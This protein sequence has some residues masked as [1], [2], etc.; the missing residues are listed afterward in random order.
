MAG[1]DL[2]PEQRNWADQVAK[3]LNIAMSTSPETA[4]PEP[5][6]DGYSDLT[7][8]RIGEDPF[9]KDNPKLEMQPKLFR[10]YE[11]KLA[12]E[13]AAFLKDVK[14]TNEAI[15]DAQKAISDATEDKKVKAEKLAAAKKKFAE[16]AKAVAAVKVKIQELEKDLKE[17]R[18]EESNR[19][20]DFALKSLDDLVKWMPPT[21]P[22]AAKKLAA[23]YDKIKPLMKEA[24]ERLETS[25][26]ELA[27]AEKDFRTSEVA[28]NKCVRNCVSACLPVIDAPANNPERDVI[29]KQMETYN[30]LQEKPITKPA[31]AKARIDALAEMRTQM[32]AWMERRAKDSVPPPRD[33]LHMAEVI[34]AEHRALVKTMIEK[35]YTP[36]PPVSGFDELPEGDR[37]SMTDIWNGMLKNEGVIATLSKKDGAEIAERLYDHFNRPSS[38]TKVTVARD[39]ETD[40]SDEGSY[41][42]PGSS[43]ADSGP[44]ISQEDD[45]SESSSEDEEEVLARREQW[46]REE[47]IARKT[48]LLIGGFKKDRY[49]I[50]D[51]GTLEKFQMDLMSDMAR[52]MSNASGRNIL[53][54]IA[55]IGRKKTDA[56]SSEDAPFKIDIMP[57]LMPMCSATSATDARGKPK[58]KKGE[59]MLGDMKPGKGSSCWVALPAGSKDGDILAQSEDGNL[60]MAPTPVLLAHEL[61]HA[62]HDMKGINRVLPESVDKDKLLKEA[63]L[64]DSWNNFEEY[65]TIAGGELSEQA[66]RN[67]YGLETARFGHKRAPAKT[68]LADVATNAVRAAQDIAKIGRDIVLETLKK[69]GITDDVFARM[70][71]ADRMKKYNA[72]ALE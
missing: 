12:E 31:D 43:D 50:P 17:I 65:W 57:G 63:G 20:F 70:S 3:L 21:I 48:N 58:S 11:A 18:D 26:A 44:I 51:A 42:E 41:D 5:L 16:D 32:R 37:K 7:A 22:D 25:K 46:E 35:D 15:N 40:E 10:D 54:E 64:S 27:G 8:K 59:D 72:V 36:P 52:L 34:Q 2:T 56:T 55:E 66:V 19:I 49:L 4:A 1:T 30:D 47:E 67:D 60:I 28:E 29:L 33:G 45:E 9:A 71:D 38:P 14:G 13:E 6:A 53:R 68:A 23:K 61:V 69:H 24:Q 39:E 62:L